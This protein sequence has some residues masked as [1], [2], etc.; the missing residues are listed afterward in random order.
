MD[1]NGVC[2]RTLLRSCDRADTDIAFYE[3]GSLCPEVGCRVLCSACSVSPEKFELRRIAY[4]K[5]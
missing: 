2:P 5:A 4:T 1:L 3:D